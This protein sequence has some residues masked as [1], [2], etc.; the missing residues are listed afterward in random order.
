MVSVTQLAELKDVSKQA[1]SRRL[2][3]FEREG[4][5]TVHHAGSQKQVSL[6]DWDRVTKDVTD[7]AKLAGR[8][9]VRRNAE[10]TSTKAKPSSSL[11]PAAVPS[12]YSQQ[13]ERKAR[14]EA[15]LREI[16]LRRLR[17][18]LVVVEDVRVA[19]EQCAEAIVRDI[20]QLPAF[21]D[22]LAAALAKGGT[23]ALRE[24]LKVKGREFRQRLSRTMADLAAPE[25]DDLAA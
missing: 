15:D 2:Q 10:K 23:L 6:I 25:I 21:A 13:Q 22:D 4:L 16:E 17:Q 3:R 20:D 24:A 5:L 7:P 8:A 1:I 12:S 11:A 18:Q 9:T 19:M 14:L